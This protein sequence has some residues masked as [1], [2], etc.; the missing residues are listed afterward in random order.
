[1]SQLSL[2]S[3]LTRRKTFESADSRTSLRS[4]ARLAFATLGV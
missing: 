2:P 1:M 4:S 3:K